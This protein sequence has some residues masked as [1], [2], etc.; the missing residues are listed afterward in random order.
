MCSVQN[1]IDDVLV[2]T[3]KLPHTRSVSFHLCCKSCSGGLKFTCCKSW[4]ESK[5]DAAALS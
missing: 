2:K 5:H 4:S 1:N 3:V